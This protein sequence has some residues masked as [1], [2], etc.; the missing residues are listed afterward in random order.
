METE[1][2]KDEVFPALFF[3][4]HFHS[5]FPLFLICCFLWM[6]KKKEKLCW[7][8]LKIKE[9]WKT[10]H[11]KEHKKTEKISGRIK[12]EKVRK[13]NGKKKKG[14]KMETWKRQVLDVKF[15][16][17][18]LGD[19]NWIGTKRLWLIEINLKI[20]ILKF[21]FNLRKCSRTINKITTI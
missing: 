7:K 15:G 3:F 1:S 12:S 2:E 17:D 10:E 11:E 20:C 18:R 21:F 9:K 14:M 19:L 8:P 6:R 16:W 13:E 5:Y 4:T